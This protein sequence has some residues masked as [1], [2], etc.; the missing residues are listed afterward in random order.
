MNPLISPVGKPGA[1]AAPGS[2]STSQFNYLAGL[3][4]D[5]VAQPEVDAISAYADLWIQGAAPNQPILMNGD[6][7]EPELGQTEFAEAAA[8]WKAIQ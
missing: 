6:T 1:W 5:A 2:M 8:A 4:M 3:D 7:L